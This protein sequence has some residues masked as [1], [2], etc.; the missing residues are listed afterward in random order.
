MTLLFPNNNIAAIKV[1]LID[2]TNRNFRQFKRVK[3]N[4]T[5]GQKDLEGQLVLISSI[6]I[7]QFN[8]HIKAIY[9]TVLNRG[10]TKKHTSP[11]YKEVITKQGIVKITKN[12]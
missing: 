9:D 1:Q 10:N 3:G 2:L 11:K 4:N 7:R 6:S 5:T 8:K 12:A